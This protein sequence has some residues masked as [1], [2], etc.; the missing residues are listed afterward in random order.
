[1]NRETA[2]RKGQWVTGPFVTAVVLLGAASI[3]AGPVAKWLDMSREKAPLGL[4]KPLGAL[5]DRA[6]G[7]FRVLERN[8]LEPTVVEA[9]G[10]DQYLNWMVEDTSVPVGDALR[11]AHLFI[12]YDTGGHNLVPHTPDECR[13][14]AGYQPSQA[15]DNVEVRLPRLSGFGES[16]PMR[17]CTFMKTAVFSRDQ[18]SV[19]YTFF[20][21]GR[22]V[23]T[24][25]GVRL[26]INDPT[27]RHAFFSKIEVSYP[28][29]SRE[30]TVQGAVKLFDYLLP[31]LMKDHFP[32]FEA[33]EK[34]AR[35]VSGGA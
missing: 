7:P 10:T 14:G 4:A 19:V 15:H 8:S 35:Q 1:M 33:A 30:Q 11:F 22:F 2:G 32:D 18:V 27:R 21:N 13:L 26:L 23:A 16:I 12:T 6:L 31:A 34:A 20:C 28:R 24:R 9:L 17:V 5:D 3:L 29:A 25:N